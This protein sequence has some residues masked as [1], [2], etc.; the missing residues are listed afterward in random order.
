MPTYD[1]YKF[2]VGK[3]Q[4]TMIAEDV[5]EDYAIGTTKGTATM[6]EHSVIVAH[7]HQQHVVQGWGGALCGATNVGA[8][9]K[10][11]IDS[12]PRTFIPCDDCRRAV[13]A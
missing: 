4:A 9:T 8:W 7:G 1:V 13:M 2:D 5:G 11:F 10:R 12:E 3:D 6:T